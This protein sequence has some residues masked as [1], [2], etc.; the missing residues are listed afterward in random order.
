MARN[1]PLTQFNLLHYVGYY[2]GINEAVLIKDYG[3]DSDICYSVETTRLFNIEDQNNQEFWYNLREEF[4][5]E[6]M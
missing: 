5:P 3:G 4:W 6:E 1:I 2:P